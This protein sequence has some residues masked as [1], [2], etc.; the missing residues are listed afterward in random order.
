MDQYQ[1]RKLSDL[2]RSNTTITLSSLAARIGISEESVA[3]VLREKKGPRLYRFAGADWVRGRLPRN[4]G[5]AR[6]GR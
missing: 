1:H 5:G 6:I 2:L 4:G 3:A